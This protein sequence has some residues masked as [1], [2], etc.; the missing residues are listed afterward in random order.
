M[1]AVRVVA[2]AA[3]K[4]VAEMVAAIAAVATGAATGLVPGAVLAVA[5]TVAMLAVVVMLV[6]KAAHHTASH[7]RD[8]QQLGRLC[9]RQIERTSSTACSKGSRSRRCNQRWR[10]NASSIQLHLQRAGR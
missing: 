3:E 1:A 9:W 2:M 10:C 4:E 6:V 5:R 8:F 7:S